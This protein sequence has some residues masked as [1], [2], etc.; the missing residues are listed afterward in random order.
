MS[1]R[2]VGALCVALMSMPFAEPAAAQ[3]LGARHTCADLIQLRVDE[4]RPFDD[5]QA[6]LRAS[7]CSTAG[8]ERVARLW[9]IP[10]NDLGELARLYEASIVLHDDGSRRASCAWLETSHWSSPRG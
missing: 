9:E 4:A 6:L 2:T 10:P 7:R 3:S 5:P 8:P 1:H